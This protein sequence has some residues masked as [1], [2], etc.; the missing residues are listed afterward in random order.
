V[1]HGIKRNGFQRE[2]RS[3]TVR[4]ASA[5]D[6]VRNAPFAGNLKASQAANI[7][8]PGEKA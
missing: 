2:R 8:D 7:V 4:F 3:L 6:S 5:L 1:E